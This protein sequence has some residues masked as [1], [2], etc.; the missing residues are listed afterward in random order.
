[1]VESGRHGGHVGLAG[2]GG[3]GDESAHP[4]G[5]PVLSPSLRDL[6]G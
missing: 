3:A 1:M 4:W 2:A 6:G 5:E